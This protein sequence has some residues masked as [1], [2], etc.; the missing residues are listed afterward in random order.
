MKL[1]LI[2]NGDGPG[3]RAKV[4]RFAL[5]ER[6]DHIQIEGEHGVGKPEP[7][8]Y[9]DAMQTL[10]VEPQDTWMV[11]DNLDWEVVAPQRLGIYTIWYDPYRDG[12]PD[13]HAAKPD[14]IIH[15]L[16]ALRTGA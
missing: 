13:G 4:V 14:R 9:L 5:T 10:G 8:A 11:G 16:G 6:F 1:A 2:T 15:E 12:I 3:Q 7:Q